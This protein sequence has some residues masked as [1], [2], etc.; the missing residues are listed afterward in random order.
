VIK[1][2]LEAYERGQITAEHLVVQCLHMLDP[3]HPDPVLKQLSRP[4]LDRI[5]QY[6]CNYKPGKMRSNYG[7]QP[8]A[9]QVEAARQWIESNAEAPSDGHLTTHGGKPNSGQ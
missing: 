4:I 6:A 5:V 9:D 3:Q 8:A 7:L 1:K 2:L